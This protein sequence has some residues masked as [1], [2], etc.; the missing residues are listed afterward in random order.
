MR[1]FLKVNF[2]FGLYYGNVINSF[3]CIVTR[4]LIEVILK[5]Y[6]SVFCRSSKFKG[7]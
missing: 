1:L 5:N 4:I 3:S 7:M 2:L 6:A